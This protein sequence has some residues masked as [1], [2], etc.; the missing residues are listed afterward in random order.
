MANTKGKIK[1]GVQ[2][3]EPLKAQTQ[4]GSIPKVVLSGSCIGVTESTFEALIGGAFIG[5]LTGAN[6]TGSK[7]TDV[8]SEAAKSGGIIGLLSSQISVLSEIQKSM[9]KIVAK[10]ENIKTDASNSILNLI[11]KSGIPVV[12]VGGNIQT[13]GKEKAASSEDNAQLEI[14]LSSNSR[15][16]FRE[17]LKDIAKLGEDK[18]LDDFEKSIERIVQALEK[19][20]KA[21]KNLENVAALFSGIGE[22]N[23]LDPVKLDEFVLFVEDLG[24]LVDSSQNISTVTAG[25]S[26]GMKNLLPMFKTIDK[27]IYIT[28]CLT[29][30]FWNLLLVDKMTPD[31]DLE[32][33][34]LTNAAIGDADSGFTKL[35]IS[36]AENE[37]NYKSA[38]NSV[39]ELTSITGRLLV[40][41]LMSNALSVFDAKNIEPLSGWLTKFDEVALQL[42]KADG[43]GGKGSRKLSTTKKTVMDLTDLVS[44]IVKLGKISDKIPE[45]DAD[46]WK[47]V[48]EFIK[49]LSDTE[50]KE[51]LIG[52]I[53]SAQFDEKTIEKAKKNLDGLRS[54]VMDVFLLGLFSILLIPIAPLAIGGILA[55]TLFTKLSKGIITSLSEKE[56]SSGIKE[57]NMNLKGIAELLIASTLCML[58][59][60]YFILKNPALILGALGFG[61]VLGLFLFTVIGAVSL[62]LRLMDNVG[63]TKGLKDV[64]LFVSVCGVILLIGGAIMAAFPGVILASFLFA[65][66]L[67]LFL[68]LIIGAVSLGGAFAKGVG[69]K[70]LASLTK[71]IIGATLVMIVGALLFMAAP[72][73]LQ[74]AMGFALYLGAFLF[75]VVL[76]ITLPGV[77]CKRAAAAVQDL[78]K[79]IIAST[80]VMIIGGLLVMNYPQLVLSGILFGVALGAFIF[81]VLKAITSQSKKIRRAK[82]EIWSIIAIVGASALVLLIAGGIIAAVPEMAWTIPLFI[83]CLTGLFF[84]LGFVADYLSKRGKNFKQGLIALGA[85]T[86]IVLL[87]TFALKMLADVAQTA[88]MGKLIGAA[89]IISAVVAIFGAMARGI[90]AV[91][92]SGIGG[93][94]VAGGV[95]AMAA[96]VG[97]VCLAA[98][99]VGLIADNLKK[100]EDAAQVKFGDV[101]K[102][103]G[104]YLIMLGMMQPIGMLSMVVALA[105]PGIYA[106]GKAFILIKNAL[107]ELGGMGKANVGMIKNN[108][109][110]FIEMA[111]E[112]VPLGRPRIALKIVLASAAASSLRWAISNIAAGVQEMASLKVPIYEGT[113]TVGYRQLNN[114]DFKLAARNISLIVST[115]GDTMITL[116]NTRPD[117]F[118]PNLFT[119][120]TPFSIVCSSVS[121]LGSVIAKIAKGVQSY[122]SLTIPEYEGEKIVGYKQLSNKDFSEAAKNI[123]LVVTTL[124]GAL[125]DLYKAN[126]EM[127]Q[128]SFF[129]SNNTPLNRVINSTKELGGVMSN[130]AFGVQS[131]A[132]LKAPIEWNNEG[133][134]IKFEKLKKGFELDAAANVSTIINCLFD[135]LIGIHNSNPDLFKGSLFN[136]DNTPVNRVIRSASELGKILSSLAQGIQAWANMTIPLEWNESGAPIKFRQM[137]LEEAALAAQNASSIITTLFTAL[138]GVYNANPSMFEGSFFRPNDT[139]INKVVTAAKELGEITSGLAKG[140]QQMAVMTYVSEYD[141]KTGKPL[142]TVRVGNDEVLQAG[143]NVGTIIT[144]L[145]TALNNVYKQNPSFFSEG[146]DSIV[147]TVIKSVKNVSGAISGIA[148]AV[149]MIATTQVPT[150]WDK[151]GKPIAFEN[152]SQKHFDLA[153]EGVA[154]IVS[155]LGG[156]ILGLASNPNTAKYFETEDEESPF[157]RVLNSVQGLGKLV[158]NIADGVKKYSEL[159]IPT[160]D[161]KGKITGYTQ[162]GPKDFENAGKNIGLIVYS[163]SRALFNTYNKNPEWFDEDNISVILDSVRNMGEVVGVI[164]EGIGAFATLS[165]PIAW[166]K[167]GKPINFKPMK[168]ED[169]IQAAVNIKLIVRTLGQAMTEMYNEMPEMFSPFDPKKP[170]GDTPFEKVALSC[171]SLGELIKN[172]AEGIE[173]FG[174]IW[175]KKLPNGGKIDEKTIKA[176]GDNIA[177]I[178]VT[179]GTAIAKVYQLDKSMFELP[180]LKN[181]TKSSG[182]IGIGAKTTVTYSPNPSDPPFLK[183]VKSCGAMGQLI[184]DLAVGINEFANIYSKKLPDGSTLDLSLAGKNI[185]DIILFI[186]SAVA[187]VYEKNPKLFDEAPSFKVLG[188]TVQGS[189]SPFSKV[190]TGVTGIVSGL[191]GLTNIIGSYATGEFPL[192]FDK[193]GNIKSTIKVNFKTD[194]Q[195][196]AENISGVLNCL[197]T[198]IEIAQKNMPNVTTALFDGV[199]VHGQKVSETMKVLSDMVVSY[200]S[201]KIPTGFDKRGKILGYKQ[202]DAGV[203]A[204][205]S[206]SMV[207]IVSGV[208]NVIKIAKDTFT[209]SNVFDTSSSKKIDSALSEMI[210]T[211]KIMNKR[212]EEIIKE[213]LNCPDPSKL[214]FT[215]IK[216]F[217]AK[218]E[219]LSSILK[220]IIMGTSV[221]TTKK[222]WLGIKQ[223]ETKTVTSEIMQLDTKRIKKFLKALSTLSHS[224]EHIVAEASF[225]DKEFAKMP[226]LSDVNTSLVS[227]YLNKSNDLA[228]RL[229]NHTI[230][231]IKIK[232]WE[233]IFENADIINANTI[234]IGIKSIVFSK[235]FNTIYDTSK[236]NLS[237]LES[238]FNSLNYVANVIRKAYLKIRIPNVERVIKDLNGIT[239]I[240]TGAVKNSESLIDSMSN[241]KNTSDIDF[242]SLNSYFDTLEYINRSLFYTS[243]QF[244]IFDRDIDIFKEISSIISIIEKAP[245]QTNLLVNVLN[246]LPNVENLEVGLLDNYFDKCIEIAEILSKKVKK[247]NKQNI[248]KLKGNEVKHILNE[249]EDVYRFGKILSS[250]DVSSGYDRL[251]ETINKVSGN[252]GKDITEERLDLFKKQNQEVKKFVKTI[253]SIDVE[254][255]DK[256][257]SLLEG[258]NK[259]GLNVKDMNKLVEA[260]TEHLSVELSKLSDELNAV[261]NI[262]AKESDRKEKRKN[263]IENSVKNV[264][265]LINRELTVVVKSE[266]KPSSSH[267]SGGSV[268]SN[269]NNNTKGKTTKQTTTKTTTTT[270]S[271]KTG[272]PNTGS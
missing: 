163:L 109:K 199:K 73:V 258:F 236:L 156:A 18:V 206:S 196:I 227:T 37:K 253:N 95:A 195:K 197:F 47:K 7:I 118:K 21:S 2:T 62:G 202:L 164:A 64:A 48:N 272:G 154:K 252:I 232:H 42:S 254:A 101:I 93:A 190:A 246:N 140:I 19:V 161:A 266:K 105:I 267:S 131:W 214:D 12:I 218:T 189:D 165:I 120:K 58:I 139:P 98:H 142:K 91:I 221:T 79:L 241:I 231:K 169:F 193:D 240:C 110:A 89:V 145:F 183:V 96:I 181:V 122:A 113:K 5:A 6:K 217:I 268:E 78:H 192:T 216:G 262:I 126:P 28:D 263:V 148:S 160:Y 4:A 9:E 244:G 102:N 71:L 1:R 38:H 184:A 159:K 80:L 121:Q 57:A 87:S 176:A 234:I 158:G 104:I 219:E 200:A 151:D 123:S 237:I 143:I 125:I 168:E 167:T 203:F 115:L 259:L 114:N 150:K 224:V 84:A 54:V 264:K 106:T 212:F 205:A 149:K 261:G 29:Q 134:P 188:T 85:L 230:E 94:A 13:S 228:S 166:D 17:L 15:K 103:L 226:D 179:I 88:P 14:I 245:Y 46:K 243:I 66:S 135:A 133:K 220:P 223:T 180:P 132:D 69:E 60:G 204:N 171:Q 198:A 178:C 33:I 194:S 49:K 239:E 251:I 144:T 100:W 24:G 92:S 25:I 31:F 249:L 45:F 141:P 108:I 242:D 233:K 99:A 155:V 40:V 76:A 129:N 116:Y 112:L 53:T 67:G 56:I 111:W 70:Y 177:Q 22:L 65:L 127:F 128:G 23:K 27:V 36:L 20:D 86:G 32:A 50:D 124:A 74:A 117:M 77:L 43:H 157:N 250:E 225:L 208:T 34:A 186:G 213:V 59:G 3:G 39:I 68:T 55:L 16:N 271:T 26:E 138:T 119:G 187:S 247:L 209:K 8:A 83:V 90:G 51:S 75:T 35:A 257:S 153:A 63:G 61:L 255:T 162:L 210:K 147:F 238:Y 136:S 172:I 137:K 146:E 170:N 81:L 72:Q 256:L 222:G 191:G 211:I 201:L 215:N 207:L 270:T 44:S 130:I 182:F 173:Y 107:T 175:G 30:I 229:N 11:N 10:V 269:Q 152:L 52:I 174:N 248:E 260:I 265:D 41:G 235:A 82:Q 185:A 97:I